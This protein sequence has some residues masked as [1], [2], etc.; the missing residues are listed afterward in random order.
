MVGVAQLAVLGRVEVVLPVAEAV[1]LL[2]L[3][4]QERRGRLADGRHVGR[5]RP[6][7]LAHVVAVRAAVAVA[8]VLDEARA[9]ALRVEV[10]LD[11]VAGVSHGLE[12]GVFGVAR[13]EL[14]CG[15]PKQFCVPC[16]VV[17]ALPQVLTF[18]GVGKG[19]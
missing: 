8:V 5:D 7:D 4:D 9:V 3:G 1:H 6:R 13:A 2:E 15:S 16:D 14:Q 12:G 10:A 18:D 19:G 17:W 11:G